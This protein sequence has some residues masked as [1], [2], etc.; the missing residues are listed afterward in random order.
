MKKALTP[1]LFIFFLLISGEM[2]YARDLFPKDSLADHKMIFEI[3]YGRGFVNNKHIDNSVV[4]RAGRD[5]YLLTARF[6]RAEGY[7]SIFENSWMAGY[8]INFSKYFNATCS[9]GAGDIAFVRNYGGYNER[10]EHETVGITFDVEMQAR[11]IRHGVPTAWFF[12]GN[13]YTTFNDYNNLNGLT[14]GVIFC[15]SKY[16][17]ASRKNISEIRKKEDIEYWER[18]AEK[19]RLR[20][21]K[22]IENEQHN[23]NIHMENSAF[24]G[25]GDH[26][27]TGGF[28]SYF[29]YKKI[30]F[31][32][33]L[34][35]SYPKVSIEKYH[36]DLAP[37]GYY[38]DIYKRERQLQTNLFLGYRIW[39]TNFFG[40]SVMAGPAWRK[41]SY[42]NSFEAGTYSHE[43]GGERIFMHK[44]FFVQSE[45]SYTF[46]NRNFGFALIEYADF[47][48][49]Y[50]SAGAAFSIRF[51][52]LR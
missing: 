42:A 34:I 28:Q 36:P 14:Y 9:A 30:L 20:E 49:G 12:F 24:V 1:F 51:G 15:P 52:I 40:I 35:G 26:V 11:I 13:Y 3:G 16:S 32:I 43:Y 8:R 7:T 46:R 41:D 23:N 27:L 44:G 48:K 19:R 45:Q 6:V 29:E 50:S 22:K 39:E 47:Y 31:G 37:A 38:M 18:K 5:N 2:T 17:P 21:I 25:S 4:A 33:S 10:I